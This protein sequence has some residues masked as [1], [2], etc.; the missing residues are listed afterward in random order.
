MPSLMV[1]GCGGGGGRG[2]FSFSKGRM[3]T[4]GWTGKEGD[5]ENDVPTEWYY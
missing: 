1:V 4:D 3:G 5:V 2:Y